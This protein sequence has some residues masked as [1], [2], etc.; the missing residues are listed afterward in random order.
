MQTTSKHVVFDIVGTIVTYDSILDALETRLGDR[1]RAE[2][3]KPTMLGYMWFEISEREYTYL[4]ITGQYHRFFDVFCSIFYRMLWIGGIKEPRSFATDE[5]LAYIVGHFKDLPLREG[6]AECLQLLRDAGFT[7]WGFTAGDT[8]QVRGYFLN[9]GIDM[10]LENFISCDDTGLGKPALDAYK[11]L[12]DQLGSDEKWFAAAHMWDASSAKK[13]GYKG[14]YCTI[15]E[16]ESCAD[17]FG[18]MDVMADTLPEM[19]RKIIQASKG[20]A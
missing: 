18:T 1:L 14:A 17:I 4:S 20:Q 11:P 5:D 2:G 6:A 19:A 10:P 16:K 13:A 15:L 8:E 7:V 12:L 9:N 3:V